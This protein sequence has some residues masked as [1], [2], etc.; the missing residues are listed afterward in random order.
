MTSRTLGT[1]V[2]G[3]RKAGGHVRRFSSLARREN[4]DFTVFKHWRVSDCLSLVSIAY[5]ESYGHFSSDMTRIEADDSLPDGLFSLVSLAR[6]TS[7][8]QRQALAPADRMHALLASRSLVAGSADLARSPFAVPCPTSRLGLA[9]AA[10][11]SLLPSALRLPL[12]APVLHSRL[13]PHPHSPSRLPAHAHTPHGSVYIASPSILVR[14]EPLSVTPALTMSDSQVRA[15]SEF[16]NARLR[17]R[18]AGIRY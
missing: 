1:A 6:L 18:L 8:P 17:S 10:S 12:L 5:H 7:W 4:L 14:Y 9:L 13:A 3:W 16:A 15:A 2:A 11:A